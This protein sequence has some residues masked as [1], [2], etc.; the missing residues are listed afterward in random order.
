MK[1]EHFCFWLQGFFELSDVKELSEREIDI[2]KKHLNMVFIHDIDP[3]MGSAKH[4]A[5]LND[6]HAG[7]PSDFNH[8]KTVFRC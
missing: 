2:I 4:Q 7:Y 3:K 6:A 8:D 5:E 1:A